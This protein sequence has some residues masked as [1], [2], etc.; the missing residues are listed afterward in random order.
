MTSRRLKS[1]LVAVFSIFCIS[2][3]VPALAGGG[4]GDPKAAKEEN[5]GDIIFTHVLDGHEFHFFNAS[6]P[7]PIIL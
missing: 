2:F 5:I 4:E 7:L 6:V 1:L 3:S